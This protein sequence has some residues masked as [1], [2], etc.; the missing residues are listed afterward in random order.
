MGSKS[1]SRKFVI[2]SYER[3][4]VLLIFGVSF[5]QCDAMSQG[6]LLEFFA[7]NRGDLDSTSGLTAVI[8]PTKTDLLALYEE[9]IE[10]ISRQWKVI[11]PTVLDKEKR[12]LL[13]NDFFYSQ[14][15]QLNK[16]TLTELKHSSQKES[17][18]IASVLEPVRAAVQT[19]PVAGIDQVSTFP[20]GY[21][22][23]FCF[24]RAL[25]VHYELLKA[26]VEPRRILKI[27]AIGELMIKGIFWR[28][29]VA[30]MVEDPNRGWFVVDPM[31][32][33]V[34]DLSDWVASVEY[35]D[36]KSPLGRTRFYVTLPE[37]FLPSYGAY[38]PN[39]MELPEFNH[40]FQRLFDSL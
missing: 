12:R 20:D 25:L 21:Q 40:Y 13:R 19:H 2:K 36:I 17:E 3:L 8:R 5:A 27:F 1:K 18:S 28:F 34:M 11:E 24:G 30:V 4:V 16:E 10:Q 14:V 31:Q 9:E 26:K 32:E 37:K 29:H 35:L 39:M 23:G 22:V 7:A 15:N 33:T 6:D 38:D